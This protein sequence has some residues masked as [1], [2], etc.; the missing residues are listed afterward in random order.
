[1]CDCVEERRMYVR[2]R[3]VPACEEMYLCRETV[4]TK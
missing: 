1:M 2:K 3:D 4:K